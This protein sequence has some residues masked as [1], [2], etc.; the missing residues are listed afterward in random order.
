[1]HTSQLHRMA[2]TNVGPKA[3]WHFLRAVYL[4][5]SAVPP[6]S[7]PQYLRVCDAAAV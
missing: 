6:V 1:M 2:L 4:A 7:S 3:E 5:S